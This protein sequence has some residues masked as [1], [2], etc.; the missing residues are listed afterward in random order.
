MPL[1]YHLIG[2]KA[3]NFI[4]NIIYFDKFKVPFVNIKKQCNIVITGN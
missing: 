1:S 4:N 2:I 3:L